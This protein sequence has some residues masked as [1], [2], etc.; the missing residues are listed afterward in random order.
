MLRK[1]KSMVSQFLNYFS[2]YTLFIEKVGLA[3][4]PGSPL[5]QD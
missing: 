1:A 4:P 2:P 5:N 3:C